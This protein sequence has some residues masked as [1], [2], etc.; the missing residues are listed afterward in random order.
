MLS[1]GGVDRPQP[2][3]C[4]CSDWARSDAELFSPGERRSF[5]AAL[6]I[7]GR[8][9]FGVAGGQEGVLAGVLSNKANK[10]II[11]AGTFSIKVADVIDRRKL[12]T[13]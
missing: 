7:A 8:E 11:S 4:T 1:C 10:A 9:G 13:G 6:T 12:I 5:Y 2:G 3:L